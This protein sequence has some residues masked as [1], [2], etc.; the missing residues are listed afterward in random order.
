MRKKRLF[1]L[2]C[3]AAVAV[4]AAFG[5]KAILTNARERSSLLME[6][7]EAISQNEQGNITLMTCYK[8]E[9]RVGTYTWKCN[10]SVNLP[11]VAPCSDMAIMKTNCTSEEIGK[12]YVPQK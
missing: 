11:N 3:M 10:S 12:C 2:P 4:A 6:N 7:V 8:K 5:T 9:A 1:M